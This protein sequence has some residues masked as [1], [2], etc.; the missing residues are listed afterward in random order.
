MTDFS[1]QSIINQRLALVIQQARR[2]MTAVAIVSAVLNV[3]LLTGSIYMMMLYDYVL[4]SHSTASLAAFA[5]IALVL[6]GLQG[7]LDFLRGR[8]L[9]NFG[10]AVDVDLSEDINALIMFLERHEPSIDSLQPVQDLDQLRNFLSGSGPPAIVDLPWMLLFITLLFF[11]HPYLGL[12]VLVGGIFLI[13]CTIVTERLTKREGAIL[14]NLNMKRM[15]L[16]EISRRHAETIYANGMQRVMMRTW[17]RASQCFLSEQER[18]TANV[19]GIGT[20][21]KVFRMILQSAVL[22]VGVLLVL[23]REATGGVIFA[24]SIISSRSLAP[25]EAAIAN[26]RGFA[27]ARQA[28]NRL[29]RMMAELPVEPDRDYLPGPTRDLVVEGLTIRPP[30]SSTDTVR[31]IA[32]SLVS[33]DALAVIGPSG[34]GKSTIA[35]ALVGYWPA[36]AGTIRLDGAE[37]DQWRPETLGRQIGYVPQAVELIQGT[38]AQNIARF[39]PDASP[40]TIV[41]AAKQAGVHDMILQMPEGYETDVGPDGRFLSGGQRQRIAL[42]RALFGDPFLIVLDEPNANLDTAGDTA[43]CSAIIEAKSRGAIVIVIAHRQTVL[44]A[45]DKILVLNQG[46]VLEFGAKEVVLPKVLG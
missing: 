40:E 5:I 20:I 7:V 12:T 34:C 43:L 4:P 31:N 16:A 21:T 3:L 2:T 1:K 19:A 39:A 42:A 46:R 44:T 17:I 15:Q 41:S 23:N 11:L 26:W 8:I 10:M 29:N 18:I 13:A 30:G 38:I 22:T 32:F 6:Y 36:I 9:I 37:F 45:V 27:S 25:V 14:N 28:W 35:R 33:G 24:S